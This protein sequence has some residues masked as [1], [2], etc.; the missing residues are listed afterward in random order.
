MMPPR[1]TPDD[2]LRDRHTPLSPDVRR[3]V[4]D[5]LAAVRERGEPALRD[6]A[7]RLDGLGP[8]DT[9]YYTPDDLRAAWDRLPAD[10]RPRLTRIAER[11]RAFAEL[12]R[13]AIR[14]CEG[15][16]PGG[17]A[18]HHLAPV[19]R[20]GCYAPGGR[21][22]LPSTVL[23]TAVTARVAGVGE[24]WV[25]SPRP[26]DI[27]LAA[28]HLADADGLLATGGAQAI[29][30]LAYGAGPVP[31]A[32]VVVGPGNVW[33]T[34]AK[35][36]VS[37]AVRID[38]LAGPSELIVIADAS[39]HPALV[40][41]DLLAQAEHDPDA[42]ALLLTDDPAVAD[43]VAR[44]V[45]TQLDVLPTADVARASLERQGGIMLC[46][47]RDEIVATCNAFAPE[48]LQLSVTRPSSWLGTLTHFGAVFLGERAAE[49]F[50]DYGAGPNHVLP[51]GGAARSVGGLSVTTFLRTRTWMRID[52]P[53]E[54]LIADTAWLARIEGLEAHARAAEER[55]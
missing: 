38:M 26:A 51:T 14:P 21:Y 54:E 31:R 15:P 7:A 55:R 12:Q 53:D 37:G 23:M 36:A 18:G 44:E 45:S 11:I 20:A 25:A 3:R 40:A 33:V 41:A 1:R 9:L 5:I 30:G 43:A 2:V 27:T 39:C 17:R 46:A 32:D 50:G 8:D 6:Y 34:A 28:A 13:S 10:A 29:A 42:T 22:P 48:H 47:N 4:D 24:V 16:I 19:A 52:E 35:E 49:V